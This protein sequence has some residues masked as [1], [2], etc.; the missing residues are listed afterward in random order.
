MK[1]CYFT[2]DL[3]DCYQLE[4]LKEFD[5]LISVESQFIIALNDILSILREKKIKATFFVLG[6]IAESNPEV[7]HL[8][9]NEGHEIASHGMYHLNYTELTK[10]EWKNDILASKKAIEAVIGK[11]IVGFRA[12]FFAAPKDYI[13]FLEFLHDCGFSYD[14][15]YHCSQL[16]R[17]SNCEINQGISFPIVNKKIMEVTPSYFS[18]KLRLP[19]YGGSYFRITP[20]FIL[21]LLLR[22]RKDNLMFYMHPYE[23]YRDKLNFSKFKVNSK[24]DFN[25]LKKN[26]FYNLFRAS[27]KFRLKVLINSFHSFTTLEGLY[28]D[29]NT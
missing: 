2:V 1:K 14:S 22:R 16:V 11:N 12:P 4:Y 8:I 19:I 10:E 21:R 15:S 17:F 25:S 7:L 13:S 9:L 6:I 27:F 29:H 5:Q 28:R 26:W 18:H 20:I 24:F 23:I 3:E